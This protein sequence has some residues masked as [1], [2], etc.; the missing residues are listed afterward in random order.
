MLAR[1]YSCYQP[2]DGNT[3]LEHFPVGRRVAYD[4]ARGRLWV[5]CGRCRRWTLAPIE[6]RWE[7]L[8][9][10]ERLVRDRARLRARTDN[11]SLLAAGDVE[12]VR[13]GEATQLREES[14]WRFG[15]DFAAR[16]RR[17]RRIEAVGEVIDLVLTGALVV[18]GLLLWPLT[19]LDPELDSDK[20]LRW[21]RRRRFGRR[22]WAGDVACERCGQPLP[23]ALFEDRLA[24]ALEPSGTALPRLRRRCRTC[25]GAARSGVLLDGAAARHVL[26]RVLAYEN[27][28]GA[29]RQTI[30][31]AV[32]VL[33]E[34]GTP[35][36]FLAQAAQRR[37]AL[38]RMPPRVSFA[39]E[40]A[41]A[42]RTERELLQLEVAALELRWREEEAL[43]A[44]VDGELTPIRST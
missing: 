31:D 12:I 20:W 27:Y 30:D 44:I 34:A 32:E 43:A 10:L 37:L 2:F 19:P 28:A 41:V 9:E 26:R 5:V 24:L 35:P 42:E 23:P 7:A 21:A 16:R 6:E 4:A 8:E 40:I 3:T 38:G 22:A 18:G 15:R 13:V 11:V 1:C 39:L 25:G 29:A 36:Q 33:E 14:H 17:A